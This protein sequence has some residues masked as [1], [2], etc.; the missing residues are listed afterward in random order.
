VEK[1]VL[2]SESLHSCATRLLDMGAA[3]E[4]SELLHAAEAAEAAA[5]AAEHVC[6]KSYVNNSHASHAM[7][8]TD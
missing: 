1:L 3:E 6:R 5:G 8:R 7:P 4:A 2:W